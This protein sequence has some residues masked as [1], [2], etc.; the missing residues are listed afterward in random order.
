[1]SSI[2]ICRL[3]IPVDL[4]IE[5]WRLFMNNPEDSN[6]KHWFVT[7]GVSLWT[8]GKGRDLGREARHA[9]SNL[10]HSLFL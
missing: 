5:D 3:E 9:P 4:L 2:P 10:I 8:F 7:E 6:L 1:M